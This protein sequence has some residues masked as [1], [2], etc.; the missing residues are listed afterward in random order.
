[1]TRPLNACMPG[2]KASEFVRPVCS[3][4]CCGP[5][6]L[7]A[8][9]RSGLADLRTCLSLTWAPAEPHVK[10]VSARPLEFICLV[11][12]FTTKWL[13]PVGFI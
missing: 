10:A 1:M 9:A 12:M 7:L 11:D 4:P 5:P 2:R 6:Q 13:D 3:A 8:G